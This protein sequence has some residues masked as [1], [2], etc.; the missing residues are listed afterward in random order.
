MKIARLHSCMHLPVRQAAPC[1]CATSGSTEI[2]GMPGL[3]R[4]WYM[5]LFQCPWL[6]ERI[7]LAADLRVLDAA[8]KT[9]PWAPRT[10]GA[11]TDEDIERCTTLFRASC[12]RVQ[13]ADSCC[14]DSALTHSS[15]G[16][17]QAG[18]CAPGSAN[19]DPQLLSLLL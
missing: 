5:V 9:G 6:P 8:F 2:R 13:A 7:L 18:L 3:G 14:L 19:S 15:H 10:P 12:L 16:Q 17:V 11:I 4:S 1:G